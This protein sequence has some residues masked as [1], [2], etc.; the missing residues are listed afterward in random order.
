MDQCSV[1]TAFHFDIQNTFLIRKVKFSLSMPCRQI[2]GADT[3]LCEVF[4][5]GLNGGDW[6]TSRSGRIIPPKMTPFPI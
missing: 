6:S 2:D 3:A 5:K 4:T 1:C